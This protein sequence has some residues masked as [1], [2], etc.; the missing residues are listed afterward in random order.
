MKSALA[1]LLLLA[2]AAH[3]DTTLSGNGQVTGSAGIGTSVPQAI[4][5]VQDDPTDTFALRVS[6]ANGAVFFVVLPNGNAGLGLSAPQ[7]HAD[8][9]G[10]GD[11]GDRALQLRV[12]NSSNTVLSQQIVFASTA[13]TF[14][15]SL[16]SQAT[17]GQTLGNTL[18]FFLW[19]SP[20]QPN[21]AASLQAL[22]LAAPTSST[23]SVHIDPF[24]TPNDELEVSNG[25]C[26]GCG[27]IIRANAVAPS[28]RERKSARRT[29]STWTR[30]AAAKRSRTCAR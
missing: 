26:T 22:S 27:T 24:G 18:D 28:S 21:A 30:R 12:G 6:S 14:G 1:S 8:M 4:L 19:N 10:G 20:G 23:W 29:S 9:N 16:L 17:A 13:G 2:A 7:A 15:H 11:S 5:H 25:L 3:A